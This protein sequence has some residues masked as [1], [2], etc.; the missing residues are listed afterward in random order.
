MKRLLVLV[1]AISLMAFS[2]EKEEPECG[3]PSACAV[4]NP[5]QDLPW[6][7][8]QVENLEK[9]SFDISQYFYIVQAD[10][11]GETVFFT[12]NCCPM[13]NTAPPTV[14]NCKGDKLFTMGKDANQDKSIRNKKVIWKG[15]NYACTL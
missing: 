10:Y 11:K 4:A 12:G 5:L 7:K 9:N 3:R 2:C 15:P 1:A 8:I 14:F 6:L 13:C